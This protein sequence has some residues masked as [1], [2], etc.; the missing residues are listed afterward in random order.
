MKNI[1]FWIFIATLFATI[2]VVFLITYD[3][4]DKQQVQAFPFGNILEEIN[5]ASNESFTEVPKNQITMY[6][7]FDFSKND[8]LLFAVDVNNNKE[9]FF[10]TKSLE[11]KEK[12]QIESLYQN[13]PNEQ[14]FIFYSDEEYIYIIK[15]EKYSYMIDGIIKSFIAN[16]ENRK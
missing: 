16:Y 11:S 7:P 3:N 5:L 10:I 6:L 4:S 1:K 12:I 13:T 9:Y 8:N 15:S 14:N 2:F